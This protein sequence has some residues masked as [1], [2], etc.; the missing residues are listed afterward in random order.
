LYAKFRALFKRGDEN[1][2]DEERALIRPLTEDESEGI[3]SSPTDSETDTPA[4]KASLFFFSKKRPSIIPRNY[5]AITSPGRQR[6]KRSNVRLSDLLL[7]PVETAVSPT[8][9]SRLLITMLSFVASSILS[10]LIFTLAATGRRKQKGEVDAGIL[11]GVIASLFFALVGL[12]SV[13][14]A[15]ESIG[16]F[17]WAV[18]GAVFC[19][20]CLAD[21]VLVGW[22]LV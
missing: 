20:V 13:L 14:T 3:S 1:Y 16:V 2:P 17:R 4:V 18:V 6:I 9:S 12:T 19:V 10:V 21:G 22:V 11:L 7:P 8:T 5:G 15:R